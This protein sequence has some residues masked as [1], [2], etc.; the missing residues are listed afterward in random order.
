MV[1]IFHLNIEALS[2]TGILDL[3]DVDRARIAKIKPLIRYAIRSF[4]LWYAQ[5]IR[6]VRMES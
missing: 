1:L 5:C 2:F 4:E 3:I 6:R